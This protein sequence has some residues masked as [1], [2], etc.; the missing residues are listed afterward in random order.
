MIPL[1]HV[2][3]RRQERRMGMDK[4]GQRD[5]RSSRRCCR[6]HRISKEEDFTTEM[7]YEEVENI[8]DRDRPPTVL[9]TDGDRQFYGG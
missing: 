3:C 9:L 1:M 8:D 7:E 2:Q 4:I 6:R 5:C